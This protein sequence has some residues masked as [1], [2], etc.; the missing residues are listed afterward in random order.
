[1]SNNDTSVAVDQ[2]QVHRNKIPHWI[3]F[4][5]CMSVC[6]EGFPLHKSPSPVTKSAV[7]IRGKK[8]APSS[9]KVGVL[10]VPS[11]SDML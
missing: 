6:A 4:W 8:F 5:G 10:T 11:N 9:R 7:Q 1:M 3:P 2:F